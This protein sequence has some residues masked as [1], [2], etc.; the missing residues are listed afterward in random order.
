M[1]IYLNN[2][3][4]KLEKSIFLSDFLKQKNISTQGIAIAIDQTIIP[5][6]QWEETL[7]MPDQKILI[8]HAVT[9]G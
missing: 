8:I 4:I 6:T 3:P 2:E 7:L 1:T 5:R 9:G